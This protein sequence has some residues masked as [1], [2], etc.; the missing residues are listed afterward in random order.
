MPTR[1]KLN[2]LLAEDNPVN[3]M[4]ALIILKKL[5]YRADTA[6]NGHEVLLALED[7]P[8]DL[9]LMDI[10]MPEMDGI[11]ATKVIRKRWPQGPKIIV[12]TAFDPEICRDLCYEVGADDFL[13]KP[14][15]AE[16]LDAA[17]ERNMGEVFKAT[18]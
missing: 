7:H 11:E 16:E 2:I 8:Y 3:R 1:S 10:Q 13:N 14:V 18:S 5:G 17:I 12:V 4:T 6:N 9:V 15:K